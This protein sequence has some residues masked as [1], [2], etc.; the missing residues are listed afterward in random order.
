MLALALAGVLSLGVAAIASAVQTTLRAGNLV[1]TFGGSTSPKAISKNNYTPVTT[2]IFGKISTSDNT[3]PSALRQVDFSID[4]DV[5]INVKGFPSCKSGE[6]TARDT[7]AAMK[8]CGDAVLGSGS[9][10]IEV[11]S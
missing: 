8:V 6:L 5:K 9:A 1:V 3:H 2:N 11:A 10:H 4:K 7:K